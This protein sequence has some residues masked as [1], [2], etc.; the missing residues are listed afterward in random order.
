MWLA[1]AD[2]MPR[3]FPQHSLLFLCNSGH[4]YENLGASHIADKVGPAPGE[5]A[6]W[7]HLGANAAARDYQEM[8]GRLLP[9]PS[10]DPYRFL[11]TS[12]EF[13]TCAREIFKGQPG[14]EMAYPS[15]EGTAGELSEVIK[16]GYVRHAGIFGAHR[17]HHAVTDDLSTVT[18]DP[19][20]ATARGVRDL[21]SAVVS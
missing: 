6:F 7:F 21:L 4:E 1:L 10:A 16:A 15:A 5:T 19:L 20:A 14:L 9:L 18:P 11:M 2:W 8:P 17:H 13:V 3:A 12:P